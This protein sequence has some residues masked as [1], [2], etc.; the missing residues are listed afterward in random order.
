MNTEITVNSATRGWIFYDA[1]CSLCAGSAARLSQTLERRG[2]RLLPLQTAGAAERV[3]VTAEALRTRVHL[4]LRDGRRVAGADVFVEVARH[5]KWVRPLVTVARLPVLLPLLRRCYDWIAANR[6]CL[7]GTCRVPRRRSEMNW[8]PLIV[9]PIATLAL[10]SHLPNWVFM[11]TMAFSLFAGCK[12]LTYRKAIA[13]GTAFRTHQVL[14]YLFGWVGMDPTPF[15]K[16]T[17]AT[18]WVPPR[19]WVGAF[20]CVLLGSGLIWGGVRQLPAT[21]PLAGGWAGMFGVILLLHFGTFHLL[22]LFWQRAGVSAKPLM[23]APLLATSLGDFWG[24][25]WNTGFHTLA[26]EFVFR[27]VRRRVGPA[28]AMLTV[29]LASGLLHELVITLPA[30]GGY[31]L[32]TAYFLLQGLGLVLERSALGS[33]FGLATGIRG[34]AFALL[35][36]AAPAFWLFPP[37][38]VRNVILPM[39]HALGAT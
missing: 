25:R 31:G 20:M 10:R 35:V 17:T 3:G 18:L 36:T 27:P 9:L 38:F 39:L 28:V 5:V 4:L 16:Q 2:F 19:E 12:W 6:Y 11:W 7:G 13:G 32:P 30:H 23:R 8:L 24:A 37:V 22:A 14:G 15:S 29:F 26:H 33:K 1:D 21:T 34:R